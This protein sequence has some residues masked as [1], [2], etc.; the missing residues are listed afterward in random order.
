MMRRDAGANNYAYVDR[1]G[2][3]VMRSYNAKTSP[4]VDTVGGVNQGAKRRHEANYPETR[5]GVTEN[6]ANYSR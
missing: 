1:K 5:A 4:Q 6:M 3:D 2:R